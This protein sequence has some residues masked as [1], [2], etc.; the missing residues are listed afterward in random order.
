[1]GVYLGALL[2]FLLRITDVSIGTLRVIYMV[3]GRKL[4][5]AALGFLEAGVF[6]V[7]ISTVLR[8]LGNPIKMLAYACGF[9]TGTLLGITLENWIAS[10]WLMVR[11]ISIDKAEPLMRALREEGFGVTAVRGEGREGQRLILFLVT[12]RRRGK[13][14][15]NIVRAWDPE[16]FITVEPVATAIGGHIPH[17]AAPASVRK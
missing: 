8:D 4:V 13:Q 7:A 16:A 10:G 6:I 5:A 12:P 9:A 1:M 3:R 14:I 11:I 15:L 17:V 2:I